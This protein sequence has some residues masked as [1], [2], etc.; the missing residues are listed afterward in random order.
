LGN[1][2]RLATT[3]VRLGQYQAAVDAAR[4][5]N[6]LRTWKEVCFACVDAKQFRLAQICG[7]NI[8]IQADELEDLVD[9]Y[10]KRGYFDEVLKLI[11]YFLIVYIDHFVT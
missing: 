2:A 8:A 7:M 4:K 11:F 6:S 9:Y 1:F 5:G 10:V 3:L